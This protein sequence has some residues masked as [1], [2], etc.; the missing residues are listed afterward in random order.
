MPRAITIASDHCR[1]HGPIALSLPALAERFVNELW[2]S[3]HYSPEQAAEFALDQLRRT[4]GQQLRLF[5]FEA[6]G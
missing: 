1:V 2:I 3:Q 4:V 5:A 6:R